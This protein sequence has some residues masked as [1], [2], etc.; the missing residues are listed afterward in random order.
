VKI[1]LADYSWHKLVNLAHKCGF[2]IFEGKHHT[3]IK[4]RN[5]CFITTIPRHSRLKRETVRG[6]LEAFKRAGADISKKQ[7]K[8][9]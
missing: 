8:M 2:I 7:R 1:S 3:K 4:D 9:P 5:G 6:I